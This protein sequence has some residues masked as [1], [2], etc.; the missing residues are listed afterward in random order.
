[1]SEK[2]LDVEVIEQSSEIGKPLACSGHVSPDIWE[3]VDD[4]ERI[5]QNE[6]SGARFHP[7][8]SSTYRF[9][10]QETVSYVIDRVEL[11]KLKAEESKRAGTEYSLG[12]KVE[13]I[14]EKEDHVEVETGLRSLKAKM[15]AGCDG[16]NSTVRDS[17]D[18][19]EPDHFYQGMLCFSDEQDSGDFVDVFTDVPSFFGWR[20]PRTDSVEYGVAAPQGEVPMEWLDRV[21]QEYI[22]DDERRN[23]CAGAIPVEPPDTVTS[24]RVFLVG[25]SA[26][27]TKPFTGGGILYGMRC[28]QEAAENIEVDR[29]RTLQDYE[30][31]WRDEIGREIFLGKMIE[32]MYSMP[33]GLQKMGMWLFKGEISVHMDRPTTVFSFGQ[34]R[35]LFRRD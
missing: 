10:S 13:N 19:P 24:D 9:Y 17:V 27:Q 12:E 16:A 14:D 23:I 28:A 34:I 29:P 21:T 26:A 8:G 32:K 22:E 7:D 4:R 18:L 2:G 20:I 31:A 25:D 11:D 35:S 33:A 3:F 6:I 1:M 15:V 30:D 5:L